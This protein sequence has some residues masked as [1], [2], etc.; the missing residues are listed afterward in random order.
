[1]QMQVQILSPT[2]YAPV[3]QSAEIADLKSVQY[4]FESDLEHHIAE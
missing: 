2:L 1:M 3:I 4:R